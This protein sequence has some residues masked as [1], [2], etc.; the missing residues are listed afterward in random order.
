MSREIQRIN[1]LS[2]STLITTEQYNLLTHFSTAQFHNVSLQ[3]V[4]FVDAARKED[5]QLQQLVLRLSSH[6]TGKGTQACNRIL[7]SGMDAWLNSTR[8]SK[9]TCTYPQK[10]YEGIGLHTRTH[11]QTRVDIQRYTEAGSLCEYKSYRRTRHTQALRLSMQTH[12]R[13]DKQ[14]ERET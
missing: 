7:G 3:T 8:Q 9:Q 13:I 6:W 2:D 5:C 4:L 10:T 1:S 11:T 12:S 14:R